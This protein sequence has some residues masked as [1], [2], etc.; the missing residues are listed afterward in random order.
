MTPIAMAT[1]NTQ[2]KSLPSVVRTW[3]GRCIQLPPNQLLELTATASVWLLA[4]SGLSGLVGE[5][6][7]WRRKETKLPATKRQLCS[8]TADPRRG[9][10]RHQQPYR[11][12]YFTSTRISR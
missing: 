2:L 3:S 11:F 4:D 9:P 7:L 12:G 6:L 10:Y 1:H 5:R 8:P